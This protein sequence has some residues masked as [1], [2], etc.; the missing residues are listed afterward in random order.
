MENSSKKS[1]KKPRVYSYYTYASFNFDGKNH[2]VKT[3]LYKVGIYVI[4]NDDPAM[5]GNITPHQAQKL[6]KEIQKDFD[7]EKIT[8]LVLGRPIKVTKDE[9]GFLVEVD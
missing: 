3:Q 5:Q 2:N 4:W 7:D 1:V 6:F 8:D 9:D